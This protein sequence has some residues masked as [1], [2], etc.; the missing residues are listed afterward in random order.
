MSLG[1]IFQSLVECRMDY[2]NLKVIHFSS[3]AALLISF[4]F[5]IFGS[6]VNQNKR[7]LRIGYI[8]FA[9]S[10]VTLLASAHGL[11]EAT[12]LETNFPQWA[13]WK[14]LIFLFLGVGPLFIKWKPRL[15]ELHFTLVLILSFFA[16]AL[17]VL[18]PSLTF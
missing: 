6:T 12:G 15:M 2:L 1:L 13:Q 14:F 16:I 7:I 3:I 11:V 4:G 18:K 8:V 9:L 5:I 10:L 17:A